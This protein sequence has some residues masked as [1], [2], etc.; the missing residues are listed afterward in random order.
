MLFQ[1]FSAADQ[2]YAEAL[3]RLWSDAG[4]DLFPGQLLPHEAPRQD[5]RP[6][7]GD[8]RQKQVN[9][10]IYS[11]KNLQFFN[12]TNKALKYYIKRLLRE[13][14]AFFFYFENFQFSLLKM[15]NFAESYI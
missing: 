1:I 3:R 9:H 11:V 2:L 8:Q 5:I 13:A 14:F 12:L 4:P 15:K 6:R 7:Q 10:I